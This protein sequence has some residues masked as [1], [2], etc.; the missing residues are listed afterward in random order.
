ME[1][2]SRRNKPWSSG[3]ITVGMC[4][5]GVDIPELSACI[6]IPS[7]PRFRATAEDIRR[8]REEENRDTAGGSD[9]LPEGH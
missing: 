5:E 9:E 6:F 2:R 4:D 3:L 7:G 8:E 1:D